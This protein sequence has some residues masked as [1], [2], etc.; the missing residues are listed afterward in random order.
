[1]WKRSLICLLHYRVWLSTAC[2]VCVFLTLFF[3]P[4]VLSSSQVEVEILQSA[5]VKG[6]ALPVCRA[7]RRAVFPCL[8]GPITS[9]FSSLQGSAFLRFALR[10]AR[11]DAGPHKPQKSRY[12]IS[13]CQEPLNSCHHRNKHILY[14]TYSSNIEVLVRVFSNLLEELLTTV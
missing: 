10:K 11:T 13:N 4:L 9:I 8:G 1:M 5:G 6:D 3:P 12:S 14:W 7:S 2:V